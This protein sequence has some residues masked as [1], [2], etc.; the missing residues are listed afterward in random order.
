MLKRF[1]LRATLHGPVS[2]FVLQFSILHYSQTRELFSSHIYPIKKARMLMKRPTAKL[3][4]H[5]AL[6]KSVVLSP[7]KT[8]VGSFQLGLAQSK[9]QLP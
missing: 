9:F 3:E 6:S 1:H 8:P 7:L 5:M 2:P 4:I